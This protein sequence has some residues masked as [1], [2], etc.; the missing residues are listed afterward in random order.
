MHAAGQT[1][2]DRAADDACPAAPARRAARRTGAALLLQAPFGTQNGSGYATEGMSP[3]GRQ[4]MMKGRQK[5][6]RTA[7]A[8]MLDPHEDRFDLTKTTEHDGRIE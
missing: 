6:A 8:C 7:N 4:M 1:L 2:N 3:F 5:A